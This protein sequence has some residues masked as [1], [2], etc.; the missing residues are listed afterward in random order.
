M[1]GGKS[2]R[3]E[4]P[5]LILVV[6]TIGFPVMRRIL[7]GSYSNQP[8]PGMWLGSYIV[9]RREKCVLARIRIVQLLD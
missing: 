5:T 2:G 1:V 8:Q 7:N 3:A 6:Q 9:I 4:G